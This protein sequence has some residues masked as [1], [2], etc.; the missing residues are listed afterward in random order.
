L[1]YADKHEHLGVGA[2]RLDQLRGQGHETA[3][4]GGYRDAKRCWGLSIQTH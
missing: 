3:D 4:A 1:F 2:E